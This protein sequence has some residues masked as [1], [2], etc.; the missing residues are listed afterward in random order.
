MHSQTKIKCNKILLIYVERSAT[1][2]I[3]GLPSCILLEELGIDLR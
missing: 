3:V 2:N 1:Y